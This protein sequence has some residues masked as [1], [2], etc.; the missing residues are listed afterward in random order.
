MAYTSSVIDASSVAG[1]SSVAA[2]VTET[3]T[4]DPDFVNQLPLR[5]AQKS[6]MMVIIFFYLVHNGE[7]YDYNVPSESLK[8]MVNGY[9]VSVAFFSYR[10]KS[11]HQ[12]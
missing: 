4:S 1:D 7:S 12:A 11:I 8:W 10:D 9:D 6:P 3:D 5:L 2:A